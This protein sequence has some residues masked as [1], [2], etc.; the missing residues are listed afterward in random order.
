VENIGPKKGKPSG[1]K[2][3]YHQDDSNEGKKKL[4][5]KDKKTISIAHQCKDPRN[6]CN[7]CNIDGHTEDKCWKLHPKMNPKNNKKDAKKKNLLD[8]D[9]S[10]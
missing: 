10:N 5:I 3:K 1:S 4:K 7:R 2:Q 6:H 9:L 8:I